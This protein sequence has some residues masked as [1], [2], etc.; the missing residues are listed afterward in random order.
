VK[1]PDLFFWTGFIGS[2]AGALTVATI[3]T[4]KMNHTLH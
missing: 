2:L 1:I 3:D 4:G